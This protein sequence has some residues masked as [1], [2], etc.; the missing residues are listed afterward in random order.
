MRTRGRAAPFPCSA[1]APWWLALA[2]AFVVA[3]APDVS[4]QTPIC[5]TRGVQ[6]SVD[7]PMGGRHACTISTNGEIVLSVLPEAEPIN[8]SPWYAFRLT[9]AHALRVNVTLEYGA[10]KHRYA[11]RITRDGQTW[12]A[13]AARR[14]R[15]KR[16][17]HRAVL[18]LELPQG[19]SL[20][21]G[22]PIQTTEAML[23]WM[24]TTLAPAAFTEIEYG[25]SHDGRPLIAFTAG[26]RDAPLVVA[27][28]RQHP[29]ETTGAGAFRAFVARLADDSAAAVAF[30][31]G[32][33][34]L[35]APAPNPD[36]VARGH[37][38]LNAGG[39][40]LNRDWGRFSQPETRALGDLI[41]AEAQGRPMQAFLDFHSTENS[42][43]YA[44]PPNAPSP[45]MAWLG[46]L[47]T[48]LDAAK[49]PPQWSYTH[50]SEVGTSKGWA[51][52]RFAAPGITVELADAAPSEEVR[53]TGETIASALIE[54]FSGS[55]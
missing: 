12:T 27:L 17:G 41:T 23:A 49:S 32:H 54:Y 35:L 33:R 50:N 37:W 6:V 18:R 16:D 51:L 3:R 42:V 14:V 47:R 13:L 1:S 55:G 45:T 15:V 20:I 8:P 19:D 4:A 26:P 21:A 9:A 40:D 46:L 44:P 52:E 22:Q 29:P 25:H 5:E 30:R 34:L 36:G 28:T 2:L 31:A 43:I 48:R 39:M 24:R 11:P 53:I 38:R 10:Y 7:F